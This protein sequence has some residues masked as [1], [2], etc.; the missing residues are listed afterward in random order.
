MDGSRVWKAFVRAGFKCEQCGKEYPQ[1]GVL[2]ERN[3]LVDHRV[4]LANGGNNNLS[5]LQV[6]CKGCHG[7][8]TKREK[9]ER[10]K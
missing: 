3:L 9:K 6:L 1:S 5:N 4:P 7:E 8:K 2:G 10:N